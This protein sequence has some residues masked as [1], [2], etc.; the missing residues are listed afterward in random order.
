MTGKMY[1]TAVAKVCAWLV[2]I[3]FNLTFFA[4]FV[5]GSQGMPRRY[6]TYN[7]V[8]EIWHDISTFGSFLLGMALWFARLPTSSYSMFAG[9]RM[10]SRTNG[11]AVSL[12]WET[13]SPPIHH[14]FHTSPS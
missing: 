7:P 3:G 8:Y 5:M 9:A 4:Q 12:E 11:T 1:N 6:H 10:P 13:Q 2:F 14:N